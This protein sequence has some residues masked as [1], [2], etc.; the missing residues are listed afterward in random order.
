MREA[1]LIGGET[2]RAIRIRLNRCPSRYAENEQNSEMEVKM[3]QYYVDDDCLTVVLPSEL[4]DHSCQSIREEVLQY[5]AE[6][7]IFCLI[8]DF[9][10]T[11]FMDSSGI[12]VI[13]SCCRHIRKVGGEM[14]IQNESGRVK[15]LLRIS[16]IYQ[17]T[18]PVSIL[19]DE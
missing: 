8:F 15:R 19:G 9:S 4:D 17:L 10:N 2:W 13:I 12:G 14:M 18:N 5:L 6:D 1:A 7:N 16:G 3:T 11:V